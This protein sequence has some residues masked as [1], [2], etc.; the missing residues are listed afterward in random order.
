MAGGPTPQELYTRLREVYPGLSEEKL[1][2]Q[3]DIGLKTL[4]RLK[5][6]HGTEFHTTVKLLDVAGWLS[7]DGAD[8]RAEVHRMKQDVTDAI[9]TL[10]AFRDGL[11]PPPQ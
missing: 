1:S 9:E 10:T 4:Q 3:L 2:R 6:G 8:V 11:E 5:L 7:L